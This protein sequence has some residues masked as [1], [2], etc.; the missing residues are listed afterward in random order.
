MLWSFVNVIHVSHFCTTILQLRGILLHNNKMEI[1]TAA[2]HFMEMKCSMAFSLLSFKQ[3]STLSPQS[4]SML[5][6]TSL[7]PKQHHLNT[8]CLLKSHVCHRQLLTGRE[9]LIHCQ[10]CTSG[11]MDIRKKLLAQIKRDIKS[12]KT[13]TGGTVINGWVWSAEELAL[14]SKMDELSKSVTNLRTVIDG[15]Y[16]LMLSSFKEQLDS[17]PQNVVNAVRSTLESYQS[18]IASNDV[19]PLVELT[20]SSSSRTSAAI[21]SND[22]VPLVEH[23]ESSLSRTSAAI[24]SNDVVPLVEHTESSSSRTSAASGNVPEELQI[25]AER[26]TSAS[27]IHHSSIGSSWPKYEW[28]DRP[29]QLFP[30]DFTFPK[31]SVTM[32]WDA[33]Y[34]GQSGINGAPYRKLLSRNLVSGTKQEITTQRI[35]FNKAKKIVES[36]ADAALASG[37]V[38]AVTA[39]DSLDYAT[40]RTIFEKHFQLLCTEANEP[41]DKIKS[42]RSRKADMSYLTFYDILTKLNRKKRAFELI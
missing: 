18:K 19:V 41:D 24:V 10:S 33:W 7:S 26:N 23:T 2:G 20:E 22:V 38:S 39:L 12:Q 42:E 40:S 15:Q 28:S 13:I 3:T 37:T 9:L 5:L 35:Y 14:K 25:K 4:A 36:I 29:P 17:V 6:T 32:L 31:C 11:I 8:S 30:E 16:D 21:V 34:F 1:N 27:A